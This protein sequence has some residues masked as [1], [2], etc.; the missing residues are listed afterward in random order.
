MH[1]HSRYINKDIDKIYTY[2]CMKIWKYLNCSQKGAAFK[3]FLT[4]LLNY[5]TSQLNSLINLISYI[6]WEYLSNTVDK[7]RNKLQF[8][9]PAALVSSA[10]WWADLGQLPGAHP[11]AL[12]LPLLKRMWEENRVRNLIGQHK[13]RLLTNY[14]H[15]QNRLDHTELQG[16]KGTSGDHAVQPPAKA[17]SLKCVA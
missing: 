8:P 12:S 11:A 2:T 6:A 13:E 3:I 5:F 17:C 15:G 7:E 10:Q 9:I 14:H 4:Y 1:M 16:L